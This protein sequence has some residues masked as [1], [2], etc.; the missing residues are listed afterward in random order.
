MSSLPE[1][2]RAANLQC[3]IGHE[4]TC[5]PCHRE[6]CATLSHNVMVEASTGAVENGKSTTP[7]SSI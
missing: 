6:M 3:H 7:G 5:T 4:R 2:M 1:E